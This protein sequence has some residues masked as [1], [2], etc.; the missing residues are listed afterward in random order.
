MRNERL[1]VVG[2][3]VDRAQLVGGDVAGRCANAVTK[4]PRGS[5]A[6]TGTKRSASS[7]A[8]A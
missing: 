2:A 6:D 7:R 3:M 4:M 8:P 1:A 5:G